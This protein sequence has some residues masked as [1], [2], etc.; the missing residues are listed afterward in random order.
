MLII[1]N[2]KLLLLKKKTYTEVKEKISVII[3]DKTK[4]MVFVSFSDSFI[5]KK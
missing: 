1:S 5:V 4:T 3:T 2:K